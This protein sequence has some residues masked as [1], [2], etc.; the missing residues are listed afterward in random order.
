MLGLFV[1][2]A[3]FFLFVSGGA[4]RSLATARCTARTSTCSRRWSSPGGHGSVFS[5][6]YCPG[7]NPIEPCFNQFKKWLKRWGDWA[8]END[9]TQVLGFALRS[10]VTAA[11]V[12]EF[13]RNCGYSVRLDLRV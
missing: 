8:A 6:P 13:H 2:W 10:C 1:L 3:F 4:S 7:D 5:P 12:A 11:Q 9:E